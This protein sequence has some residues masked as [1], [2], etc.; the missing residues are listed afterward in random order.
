LTIG[1]TYV[2]PLSILNMVVAWRSVGVATLWF[3][4]AL[5]IFLK[6]LATYLYL[7]PTM[8]RKFRR[9][10]TMGAEQLNKSVTLWTSLSPV[11]IM[12]R[13]GGLD[14]SAFRP[15]IASQDMSG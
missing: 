2:G 4:A 10:E 7:A 14:W 8:M 5:I 3:G 11:R 12:C 6:S 9:V 15:L 13:S 1:F